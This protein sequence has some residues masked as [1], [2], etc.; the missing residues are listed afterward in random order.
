MLKMLKELSNLELSKISGGVLSCEVCHKEFEDGEEVFGIQAGYSVCS[1][2]DFI[3]LRTYKEVM[4]TYTCAGERCER[5]VRVD[6]KLGYK[7]NYCGPINHYYTY[8]EGLTEMEYY[9]Y[10]EN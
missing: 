9:T 4:P 7:I 1:D 2:R 6:K 8:R 5:K 10:R 3:R